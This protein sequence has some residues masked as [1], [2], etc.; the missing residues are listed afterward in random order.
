M[1]TD[2]LPLAQ[3]LAE[4]AELYETV[5]SLPAVVERAGAKVPSVPGSRMP[6][7]MAE[8]LDVDEHQRALT[9]LDEWAEF[10]A[11][12]VLDEEP[13]A[14][15]A[16][17]S[18]PGRLRFASRWTDALRADVM[19]AYALEYDAREHLTALRRLSRRG[20]RK[21]P[22]TACLDVSCDGT[23]VATIAGADASDEI[24]CA[25]CG[26]VVPRETWERWGARSEWVT[27]EHA[28]GMLGLS[29]AAVRQR[30]KRGQWKR[31][32]DGRS[33]RYWTE[34]VTSGRMSA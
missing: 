26:D 25:R 18:T 1:T 5:A 19:L 33:V 32:G 16:P 15:P 14:G 31:R 34:D 6:P 22:T 30:A 9:E 4:T 21:V 24:R 7:G 12:V 8:V 27:V 20:T 23:Y 13:T 11:H 29:Q 2:D 3:V 10:V 17:D 28:A